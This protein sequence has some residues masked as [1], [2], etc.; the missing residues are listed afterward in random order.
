MAGPTISRIGIGEQLQQLRDAAGISR[1]DA[2]A[3]IDRSPAHIGH[4]ENG[5]NA[6]VTTGELVTLARDLYR[7]SP[8]VVAALEALW[9][10]ANKRG[11][12][13]IYGLPNWLARY[14]GLETD[15]VALRSLKLENIHGLLQTERYMRTLYERAAESPS[16]R[17]MDK[18]VLM[19]LHRQ[20]RIVGEDPLQLIAVVSQAAL[21]RCARTPSVARGQLKQLQQRAMLPNVELRVLPFDL[22]VHAGQNGPFSLLSFPDQLLADMAYQEDATGGRL[23]DTPSVV[24]GLHALFEELLKHASGPD[25]SIA[26][27]A[28]L[29]EQHT[30]D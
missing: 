3:A 12:W 25:E 17:E 30:R 19:R 13:S 23:T 28:Q 27:I 9:P 1:N 15:A 20:Q 5:R 16:D 7:A 21:E 11:R 18:R 2:A 22:G 10:D 29:T 14:V 6:P 26:M 8:D 4:V 24:A